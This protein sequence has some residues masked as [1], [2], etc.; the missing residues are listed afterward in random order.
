M[1]SRLKRFFTKKESTE[2]KKW[3]KLWELYG[4]SE[5]NDPIFYLCDYDSGI[6]GEG[7]LCFFDNN[8]DCL[9]KYS[10]ELK[11]VMP[12]ELYKNFARALRAFELGIDAE[13]ICS[14]SDDYFYEHEPDI[15]KIIQSYANTLELS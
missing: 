2:N 7:H 12:D 10:E 4:N 5:W 1:F 3:N 8:Q 11:K 15:I 6:N 14:E 9:S 13:K